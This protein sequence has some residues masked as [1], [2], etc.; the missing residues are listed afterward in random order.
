MALTALLP[1]QA[2]VGLLRA[3]RSRGGPSSL[4]RG[5]GLDNCIERWPQGACFCVWD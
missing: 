5:R 3:L 2:G 4:I 1:P